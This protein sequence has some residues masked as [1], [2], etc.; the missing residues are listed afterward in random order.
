MESIGRP[1]E[2]R[3]AVQKRPVLEN[4]GPGGRRTFLTHIDIHSC[5]IDDNLQPDLFGCQEAD[6][7]QHVVETDQSVSGKWKMFLSAQK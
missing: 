2:P 4:G 1:T 7:A 5:M 3:W 6:E